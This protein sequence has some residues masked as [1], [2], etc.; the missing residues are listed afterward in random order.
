[1]SRGLLVILGVE[2][3]VAIWHTEGK[4]LTSQSPP[5]SRCPAGGAIFCRPSSPA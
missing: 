2:A 3:A 1:M 4:P 5:S